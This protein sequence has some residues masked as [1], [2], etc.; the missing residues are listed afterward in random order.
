MIDEKKGRLMG[1]FMNKNYEQFK[2]EMNSLAATE[3]RSLVN[4]YIQQDEMLTFLSIACSRRNLN[5]VVYLVETCQA[6]MEMLV[7]SE[8]EWDV[9]TFFTKTHSSFHHHHPNHPKPLFNVKAPV[10]WHMARYHIDCY[11]KIIKFLVASGVNVNSNIEEALNST[12]LM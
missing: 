4:S 9:L 5:M 2:C 11:M 6:D 7:G 8:D 1:L 12:S 3:R 10:L